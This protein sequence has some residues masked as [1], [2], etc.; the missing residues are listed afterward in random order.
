MSMSALLN[1]INSEII[2]LEVLVFRDHYDQAN[3]SMEIFVS[4]KAVS[5]NQMKSLSLGLIFG[6]V[7]GFIFALIRKIFS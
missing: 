2:R 6:V 7:I 3:L 5:P 4:E 1:S